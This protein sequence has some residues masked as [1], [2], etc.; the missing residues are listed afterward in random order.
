MLKR[1]IIY[2]PN[3]GEIT[4]RITCDE[5]QA[6]HYPVRKEITGAEFA[7]QPELFQKVDINDEA[8]PLVALGEAE[9]LAKGAPLKLVQEKVATG[10]LTP[11]VKK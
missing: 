6:V 5:K 11:E 1:F 7:E 4:G 3:T 2:D 8:A 10:K 9:A